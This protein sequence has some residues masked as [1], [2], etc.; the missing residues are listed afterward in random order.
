MP[1]GLFPLLIVL[2]VI[3]MAM[4][5]WGKKHAPTPA[6]P[7]IQPAPHPTPHAIKLTPASPH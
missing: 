6:Q 3:D 1:R 5:A 4:P 7:T 2:L